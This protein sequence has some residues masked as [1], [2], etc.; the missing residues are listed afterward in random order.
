MPSG[1]LGCQR[2]E[3]IEGEEVPGVTLCFATAHTAAHYL[4]HNNAFKLG[5]GIQYSCFFYEVSE[6]EA[7]KRGNTTH[8][9]RNN[10]IH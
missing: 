10:K 9:F 7:T 4:R 2:S 6:A 3:L 5:R 8:S 1:M